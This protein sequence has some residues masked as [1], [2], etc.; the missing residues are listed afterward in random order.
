MECVTGPMGSQ[1]H[2]IDGIPTPPAAANC[3]ERLRIYPAM[4]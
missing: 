2:R 3:Q 4:V 1:F